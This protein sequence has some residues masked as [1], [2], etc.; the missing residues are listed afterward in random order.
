MNEYIFIFLGVR[1]ASRQAVLKKKSGLVKARTHTQTHTERGTW[2]PSSG[3][4]VE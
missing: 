1:G 4:M 3:L 2:F